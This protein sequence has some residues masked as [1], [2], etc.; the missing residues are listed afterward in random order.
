M[1]ETNQLKTLRNGLM[2]SYIT[3]DGSSRM[4][5]V[6]EAAADAEDGASCL[7]TRYVYSG[8]TTNI[9]KT[10]ESVGTWVADDMD[11]A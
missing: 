11:I 2:K 6:Y 1:S 9:V 8:V 4:E 10:L 7:V 5:Y 3:Y